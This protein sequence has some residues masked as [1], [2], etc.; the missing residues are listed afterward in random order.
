MFL[1][2]LP[3]TSAPDYLSPLICTQAGCYLCFYLRM[4]AFL[5]TKKAKKNG[6]FFSW[7]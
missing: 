7:P 3:F 2:V 4:A 6:K 1:F 5:H